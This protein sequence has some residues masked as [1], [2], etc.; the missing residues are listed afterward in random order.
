M[1][2]HGDAVTEGFGVDVG[3]IATDETGFFQGT[4]APKAGG[5][6][7]ARAAREFDVGH[8][9]VGLKVTQNA[10]VNPVEFDSPHGLLL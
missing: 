10:P 7:N 1:G 3:M 6:R 4:Y 8:A 5:R 2:E 9:T